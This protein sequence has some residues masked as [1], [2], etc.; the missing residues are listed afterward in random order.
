[1]GRGIDSGIG[2]GVRCA[3][4]S[5]QRLKVTSVHRIL[6]EYLHIGA[7]SSIPPIF[8]AAYITVHIAFHIAN[9]A[10]KEYVECRLAY[11]G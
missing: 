11:V 2:H 6:G 9:V 5:L 10:Y 3:D 8:V 4:F 7:I 1:V